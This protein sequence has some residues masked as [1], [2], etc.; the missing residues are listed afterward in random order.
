MR[1]IISDELANAIHKKIIIDLC[2]YAMET[3]VN[4]AELIKNKKLIG[5]YERKLKSFFQ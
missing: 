5:Y 3:R 1:P 2:I 4:K